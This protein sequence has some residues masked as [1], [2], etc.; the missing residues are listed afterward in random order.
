MRE[1]SLIRNTKS[2]EWKLNLQESYL[3]SWIYELPSWADKVV[4]GNDIYYFC[5]KTKIVEE[6]PLLSSKVDTIY[7]HI[8]SLSDKGVIV[9]K[10]IEGRDY[11]MITKKGTTW[12]E[13]ELGRKNE[14]SEKNPSR[15][16]KKSESDSE[17]NPTDNYTI[18]DNYTKDTIAFFKKNEKDSE[19]FNFL[20]ES[21]MKKFF[22]EAQTNYEWSA[23]DSGHVYPLINAIHRKI[24]ERQGDR[25]FLK[26]EIKDAISIFLDASWD[27]RDGYFLTGYTVSNIRSKFNEIF[28]RIKTR[29]NG[30]Q[31]SKNSNP[32]LYSDI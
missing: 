31:T 11:L 4:V 7:R 26:E 15:L 14:D 12:N 5:S 25:D 24:V 8:R 32:Y 9:S 28:L 18:Y 20:K 17:K 3:F 19:M 23:K 27:L 16:G 10:K 21:F 13:H 6:L 2:L 29:Q 1:T 30:K 22:L